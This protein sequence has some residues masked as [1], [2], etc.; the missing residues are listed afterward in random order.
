LRVYWNRYLSQTTAFFLQTTVF[1]TSVLEGSDPLVDRR[2]A[3][4]E[5]GVGW[6]WAPEWSFSVAYKYRNQ[7]YDVDADSA[8]SNGVSATLAWAPPRRR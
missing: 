5:T 7:K 3:E 8:Q 6:H 4:A 2:Y 1:R